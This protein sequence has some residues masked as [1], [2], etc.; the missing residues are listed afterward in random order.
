LTDLTECADHVFSVHST[1]PVGNT[2]ADDNGGTFFAFTTGLD[3]QPSFASTGSV[4][5]PDNNPNGASSTIAVAANKPVVDVDVTVNVTHLSVGQLVLSLVPP[6]GAPIVL[7]NRRGGTGDHLT[8]TIFDDEAALAISAGT[9]PFTGRFRPDSPLSATDGILSGGNWSLLAVDAVSGT[10]GTIASWT[11]ALTFPSQACG[12]HAKVN[13]HAT[14]AD[15]CSSG[16]G[17][18]NGRWDAGETVQVSVELG[19]DGTD[20]LS[21]VTATLTSPTPGVVIVDGTA[22]YPDLGVFAAS[23]SSSPHFAVRVPQGAS[24]DDELAFDVQIDSA[25]GG[26]SGSFA[27]R[28]GEVLSPDVN[29]LLESFAGGIPAGW[30]V[31]D[32]GSGG[33]AA[34]TWTTANPGNRI[35]SPP[36]VAPVVAVDS[37]NAGSGGP[38][39]D[40]QLITPVLDLSDALTAT[41]QFDQ[42]FR[43]FS[44]NQDEKGDVDVRSSLTGGGWVNVFR[45]RG[46]SSANPDHRTID[47]TAQAAGAS[48]VQIRFHYY[49]ASFEW[50]WQ[51]DSVRVD[52]VIDPPCVMT[53]CAAPSAAKPVPALTASRV[54][55]STLAVTWDV[56]TC[57][58]PDH[59]I[60]YGSLATLPSYT[61]LGSVCGIGTTGSTTWTDVPAG[62]LWFIVTGVDGAGTEAT[63]G[64]D[65]AG[66][67]RGGGTVSGQCGNVARD[68]GASCP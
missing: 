21:N 18:G 13:G 43:W 24:C 20:G 32:G 47:I 10:S 14:V 59:Q 63:W 46:A 56:V 52:M 27:H 41:L 44:G 67:H 8:G 51:V 65:S 31:V 7:S 9:A 22:S 66:G 2:G 5:I 62:D 64:Q 15:I 19:N 45:N 30:T 39:Q 25:E 29:V 34:S 57:A 58:S 3:S 48:D 53:G 17:G 16:G 61:L 60:L 35:F 36:M 50:W 6:T 42:F 49:D 38:V 11:L 55:A 23:G 12:P 54:T 33:G 4:A 37:D 26:W 1:D 40:E 28:L 68:N